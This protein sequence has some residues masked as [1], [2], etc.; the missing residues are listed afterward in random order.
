MAIFA[1]REGERVCFPRLEVY[2]HI[3]FT[4]T[5]LNYV[6]RLVCAWSWPDGRAGLRDISKDDKPAWQ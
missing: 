1:S 5:W 6:V 4:A 2:N 3:I